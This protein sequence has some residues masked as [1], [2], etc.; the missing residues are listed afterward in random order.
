[1]D[2]LIKALERRLTIASTHLTIVHNPD[3]FLVRPDVQQRVLK[4]CQLLL[5]PISSSIELRVR[6]ELIDKQSIEKVCY[7]M[8]K[9]FDMLPDLLNEIQTLP[10]FSL[11]N[12]M[13]ACNKAELRQAAM[14]FSMASYIYD[15]H[16]TYNLTPEQ[17]RHVIN[18]AMMLYGEDSTSISEKLKAIKL[19]WDK[20][21]T[22]DEISKILLK[23][24]RQNAYSEIENTINDLNADFQKFID[25]RYFSLSNTSHVKKPKMVNKVLPYLAYK[26]DRTDKIAL[27][28]VDGM[29]YWQYLILHRE[30]E[31]AGLAPRKDC[32]LAWMP[33]ITKLSRQA[34][35]RG[36]TPN[37]NYVQSPSHENE[38]WTE[39]WM[40]YYDNSKRMNKH[41]IV[42]TH[43]SIQ[44]SDTRPFR[45]AFV[46]VTLDDVM[47]H[48]PGNKDLFDVTEN[49]A[50]DAAKSIIELHKQGFTVYIT[51][52]HGNVYSYGW[53][54]LLPEE[55]TYLY[56][57][58]SRGKRHLMYQD[59]QAMFNFVDSNIEISKELLVHDKWIVW[60]TAKCFDS[61]DIIT[62]GG[63]HFLEVV[64]PFITI[65]K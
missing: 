58:E 2:D 27:I 35:F 55:K 12:F 31:D 62:H 4:E 42:Y 8:E 9:P 57:N 60:R 10:A 47:H 1:M 41:E 46:D 59:N 36:N 52:D 29:T 14:T 50:H 51:T 32:T 64:I 44:I 5:L 53:R 20:V 26:H 6:Y 34:L 23:V 54:N 28:V 22:I 56:K 21:E 39:F 17:T 40:N 19:E 18:E 7:V 38:L 25:D 33:T 65:D 37:P 16:Y 43:G 45:Q 63:A 61:Q 49:W 48:L 11:A 3:G 15:K 30:L 13:P 24:I